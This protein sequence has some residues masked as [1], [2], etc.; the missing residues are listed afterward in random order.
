MDVGTLDD[1]SVEGRRLA[2]RVDI[3]S[4]VEG[5]GIADD[6]RLRAH[7]DTLS[8]LVERGG[9]VAVLAHQGRP[10]GDEF[11]TLAA[12]A[13]RLDELLSVPVGYEDATFSSD[14]RER[15]RGLADG[16]VVVLENT[17]FY[18]EEYMEFS[19]AEAADTFLVDGLAPAVD[20][21]VNDA[22]AAAHRSQP[23]IVGFPEVLP[24][25]AGRVMERELD[26]LGA[27][28]ETPRPRVFVL[29]GAKVPDSIDVAERVLES[30]LADEVLACG[31]VGNVFLIAD[32]VDLG[33]ETA[34]FVYDEGHWDQIDRAADLLDA[35][36]EHITL[37]RDVAVDRDGERA[38]LDLV[39]PV[40][41]GETALDVG[42][43]TVALYEEVIDEAGTVVLNGPAG[44]VERDAFADGTRGIYEAATR[45]NYGVVGGGDTA[46]ALRSLGI[47]GFDH[48]S[49][50]GGACLRMLTGE[51]MAGVDALRGNES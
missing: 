19:P 8:E 40:E 10:G 37:P 32:G 7:V 25:Y 31:V 2:V 41:E 49:T 11:T 46:A 35:Y 27:V 28:D 22:F 45:A 34:R 18:S 38:E 4:P 43:K 1:L 26:V 21:Y 9:R 48:V 30:G 16:E 17:R 51:S 47:E 42:S 13:D 50:G 23:S 39:V 6:A 29:G 3:N 5:G 12:H 33:D 24:A 20:A 44:V 15:V 36:S 14:A